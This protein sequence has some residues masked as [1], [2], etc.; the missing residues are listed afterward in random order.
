MLYS[1]SSQNRTA[2]P[3]AIKNK[4]QS[5]Q[6]YSSVQKRKSKYENSKS[7]YHYESSKIV[8]K[9][10]KYNANPI[11]KKFTYNISDDYKKICSLLS[12][13]KLK[14]NEKK[15]IKTKIQYLE[16]QM[17]IKEKE[18]NEIKEKLEEF[19]IHYKEMSSSNLSGIDI[20]LLNSKGSKNF[21]NVFKEKDSSKQIRNNSMPQRNSASFGK[22]YSTENEIKNEQN[23]NNCKIIP[24][25]CEENYNKLQLVHI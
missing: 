8:Q 20:A 4:E 1:N 6:K 10:N 5:Y 16:K 2:I 22:R 21:S 15:Q 3:K 7:N 14:E 24:K 9:V 25:N 12:E 19:G 17:H 23:L 11:S 18:I 13:L